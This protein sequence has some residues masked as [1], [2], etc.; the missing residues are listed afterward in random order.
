MPSMLAPPFD[1]ATTVYVVRPAVDPM[2]RSSLRGVHPY[3]SFWYRP[4]AGL[5]RHDKVPILDA[6]R[7]GD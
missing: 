6:R 7:L 1:H 3:R 4:P 5:R 2:R